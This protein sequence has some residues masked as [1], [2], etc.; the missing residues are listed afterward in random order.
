MWPLPNPRCTL[1]P[2]S[3]RPTRAGVPFLPSLPSFPSDSLSHSL[4]HSYSS[5][6]VTGMY[7]EPLNTA[8]P[9]KVELPT[10]LEC[11]FHCDGFA[12]TAAACLLS[13]QWVCGLCREQNRAQRIF[14]TRASKRLQPI[15]SR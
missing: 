12:E 14:P 2:L 11:L 10:G 9:P 7:W 5:P 6:S 4:H 1:A 15:S 13:L 8:G 3:P